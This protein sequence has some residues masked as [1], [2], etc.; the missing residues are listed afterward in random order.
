MKT[1][2]PG[3]KLPVQEITRN[4]TIDGTY[5]GNILVVTAAGVVSRR[6]TR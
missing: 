4:T 2:L 1:H 5:N 3:Y 6:T